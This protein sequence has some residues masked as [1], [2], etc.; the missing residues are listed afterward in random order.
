MWRWSA[1][2]SRAPGLPADANCTAD[3]A[4]TRLYAEHSRSLL[5]L[6]ALLV[7]DAAKAE[8]VTQ[9]AFAAT[10]DAWQRLGDTSTAAAFLRR[11]VVRGARSA[12]RHGTGTDGG[13]PARLDAVPGLAHADLA[14]MLGSLT[15]RQREALVLRY[16][17]ELSVA[18]AAAAM[19]VGPAAVRRHTARAVATLRT[20]LEQESRHGPSHHGADIPGG[21]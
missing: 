20:R 12:Q 8:E 9:T 3:Q 13:V 5:G 10:H 7:H 6:A 19:G 1:R 18:E 4:L 21:R 14:A 15:E 11:A 17:S 16:Y 2:A